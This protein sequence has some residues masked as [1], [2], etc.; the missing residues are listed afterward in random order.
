MIINVFFKRPASRP[1][2]VALEANVAVSLA[3]LGDEAQYVTKL[4]D[5][6]LGDTCAQHHSWSGRRYT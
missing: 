3:L 6:A 2:M 5:N 4:P 1:I